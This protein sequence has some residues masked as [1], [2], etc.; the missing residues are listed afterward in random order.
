M[1]HNPKVIYGSIVRNCFTWFANAGVTGACG[2]VSDLSSLPTVNTIVYTL[3]INTFIF[4]VGNDC[5]IKSKST[6]GCANISVGGDC[7]LKSKLNNSGISIFSG[8]VASDANVGNRCHVAL[9]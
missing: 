4:S 5:R 6:P 9:L 7:G 2:V 3:A 1:D 8:H